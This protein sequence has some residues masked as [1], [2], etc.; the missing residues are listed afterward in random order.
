MRRFL[1]ASIVLASMLLSGF[2]AS[3]AGTLYV[4]YDAACMDRMEYANQ[5]DP[6]AK[7]IIYQINASGTEKIAL[8]VGNENPNPIAQ[9]PAQTL[10]CGN[11]IFDLRF[12]QA[13]NQQLAEVYLVR[14]SGDGRYHISRVAYANYFSN[15]AG[16]MTYQSPKFQFAFQTGSGVIGENISLNK[17][18]SVV[19]FEGRIENSC[20]GEYIFSMYGVAG[21]GP[22]A[23]VI[24]VPEIGMVEERSGANM[25]EAMRNVLRLDRVND[26]PT[27]DFL[28]LVCRGERPVPTAPSGAP[29]STM[30]AR[31]GDIPVVSEYSA[32][33]TPPAGANLGADPCNESS[34]GGYH[35][36]RR[37]ENL[38]RIS[39]TYSVS[40]SQIRDWNNL[41][42]GN[43]TIYPCQKLRVS[44][45]APAVTDTPPSYSN[46]QLT[47]RSVGDLPIWKTYTGLHIVQRGETMA[48]IAMKYGYTE[49][50]FRYMNNFGPNDVAKVGQ[51]LKTSDCDTPTTISTSS[52]VP[53]SYNYNTMTPRSPVFIGD[54]TTGT[55][56]KI[57]SVTAATQGAAT[58]TELTSNSWK[59]ELR[60]SASVPP[61]YDTRSTSGQ[62]SSGLASRM[63]PSYESPQRDIPPS[64]DSGTA[65]RKTHLVGDN[66]TLFDVARRYQ[67]TT[68][69]LRRLNNLN[70]GEAV[71]PGQ[72]I[73]VN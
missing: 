56:G 57:R 52:S 63:A 1:K 5:A 55:G 41:G 46:E 10:H 65:Q 72:R 43:S 11:T 53:P 54:A 24:I 21:K 68:E 27:A 22:Y 45:S 37:G 71:I 31:S 51:N 70:P 38:Y 33:D 69:N 34:G 4:Y 47:A 50:R 32:P 17:S 42:P 3:A 61:S 15:N 20:N 6:A 36:V 67:T 39:Q 30:T 13:I 19:Q 9:M 73:F 35:I 28:R 60:S 58:E 49:H 7:F 8:V 66:E 26:R 16:A 44:A 29:S 23:N 12:A 48:S 14:A 40:V 59:T 62:V 25:E 18:A 2:A 64:Y